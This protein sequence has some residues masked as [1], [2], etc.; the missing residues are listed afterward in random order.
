[1]NLTIGGIVINDEQINLTTDKTAIVHAL[2]AFNDFYQPA[3]GGV[4]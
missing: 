1:M 4:Q 2:L 3:Q